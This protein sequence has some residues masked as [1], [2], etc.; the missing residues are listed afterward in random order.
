MRRPV[1][2]AI[3]IIFSAVAA[4]ASAAVVLD[5]Q[6]DVTGTGT[7]DSTSGGFLE[8]GQTFTVGVTGTLSHIDVQLNFPGFDSGGNA[9]LNVYNTSGGLPTGASLGSASR[10][11]FLVPS[12]GYAFQPFDVSSYAI[13][14]HAGD[15]LAYGISSDIGSTFFVR[16]TSD[17]STYAGGLSLYRTYNPAGV[18]T[19][20]TFSHDGGFQTYV[21]ASAAVGL[22]GDFNN[23]GVVDAADYVLWRDHLGEPAETPLNG[24]GDGQHG[25]DDG[26]FAL[27]RAN[28]ASS[29]TPAPAAAAA[30]PEP[31]AG[32]LLLVAIACLNFAI[33]DR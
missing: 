5:Q 30:V 9:I 19:N 10:T 29:T 21:D 18:W 24:N 26:D 13:P 27:W 11:F 17:H 25:V 1:I 20:Y 23:N 3:A 6:N 14:V 33:R 15:V 22:P 2:C 8:Q 28:F 32:V 12:G 31:V 16:T 4:S 7:A